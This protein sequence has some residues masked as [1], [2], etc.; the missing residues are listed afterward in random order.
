MGKKLVKAQ[1]KA[2]APTGKRGRSKKGKE[3]S[4]PAPKYGPTNQTV[5]P[6]PGITWGN[7]VMKE[8]VIQ[9]L[10]DAGSL[11]EQI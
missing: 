8:E 7:S 6:P 9:A 10:V 4:L 3:L 2:A 11:Q 5:P 1:D